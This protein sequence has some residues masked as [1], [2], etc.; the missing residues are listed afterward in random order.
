MHAVDN[1]RKPFRLSNDPSC[2]NLTPTNLLSVPGIQK[3]A[4][5][6]TG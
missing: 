2:S 4:S 1:P 5:P 6:K 3:R